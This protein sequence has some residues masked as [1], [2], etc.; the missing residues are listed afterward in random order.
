MLRI[1]SCLAS[2]SALLLAACGGGGGGGTP[3]GGPLVYDYALVAPSIDALD[4]LVR[5]DGTVSTTGSCG[6]VGDIDGPRSNVGGTQF[7]AFDI[8]SLPADAIIDSASL[9][10]HQE[11]VVGDP[12]SSHG[13]VIVNHVNIGPTLDA[14][15][16]WIVPV[17]NEVGILSADARQ[18]AK[19]VDVTSAVRRS[20]REGWSRV[21]FSLAWSRSGYT[22]SDGNPDFAIF[23]DGGDACG[24]GNVPTI[25]ISYRLP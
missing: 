9:T 18:E 1:A 2:L 11:A 12:Y 6:F 16:F 23:N 14:A 13:A 8:S 21:D 3:P 4:G 17:E 15:D 10:L 20:W 19:R 7:F 5:S 22:N 25:I 24:S